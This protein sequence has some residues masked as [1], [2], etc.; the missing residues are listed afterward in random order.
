MDLILSFTIFMVVMLLSLTRGVSMILP[1]LV[2]VAAFTVV[3]LRRGFRFKSIACMFARG[4][5]ESRIVVLIMLMIGCLTSLWRQTG[6]IAYFTY[7]G[8][9]LIPPGLFLLAAFALTSLMSYALGTCFGVA[10]TT[11]VILMTIARASGVSPALVGGA[12]MSGLYFG[13]RGSPAASSASLVANE[14]HTNVSENIRLMLRPSIL[15]MALCALLYAALSTFTRPDSVDAGMLA[16]FGAEFRLSPWCLLPTVLLLVLAFAGLNIK[17]VMLFNIAVSIA[18]AALLQGTSLPDV[19]RMT[20][21]GYA[22]RSAE[23]SSILSG[24]GLCSMLEVEALLLLSSGCAGIFEGTRMLASI[25]GAFAKLCKRIGRFPAMVAAALAAS[26]IFCN[27]TIGIIMCRQCM[28]RN[29]PDD[30]E[31]RTALM[32]DIE[33]SVV[34]IAGLVPWCIACSVPMGMLDCGM[35][36]LPFATYLYLLPLCWHFTLKLR[37]RRAVRHSIG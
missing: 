8:V 35:N 10:G 13:D 12:I 3:A 37:Q 6:T 5:W 27:Q 11:G 4:M 14:T 36:A 18:L 28:Q 24:G 2:G 9:Q 22:P 32:L 19:L 25:E 7:Y 26:A 34:T 16:R 20:L 33:N 21:L 1:L 23:L 17:W 30:V 29:Y 15:P 31:G